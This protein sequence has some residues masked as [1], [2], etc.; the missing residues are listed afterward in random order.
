MLAQLA[1]RPLKGRGFRL[2]LAY[3]L[4]RTRALKTCKSCGFHNI[5]N[6]EACLRCGAV[7]DAEKA[8]EAN[9]FAESRVD[10]KPGA[11]RAA[12]DRVLASTGRA[13]I[14]MGRAVRG[15][16]PEKVDRAESVSDRKIFR[17]A[18]LGLIPG[19]GQLYNRQPKKA[20]YFALVWF[21]GAAAC[22][23]SFYEPYANY[24]LYAYLAW[25]LYAFH[26]GFIT[27]IE[28]NR[29]YWTYRRSATA[30]V[31]WVFLL[32]MAMI[33][34]NFVLSFTFLKFR[35]M[36]ETELAPTIAQRDRLGID[37][38][39]YRFRE[40]RVGEIVFYDPGT[41]TLDMVKNFYVSD[42]T[43]G[44]ERIVGGPGQVFERRN[45]EFFLDG[46]AVPEQRGPIYSDEL[47]ADFSLKAPYN[48]YI[49][50]RTY[51]GTQTIAVTFPK[52]NEARTVHNWTEASLIHRDDIFGRVWFTYYPPPHRR[53]FE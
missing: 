52:M 49:I 5:D 13:R 25:I 32:G 3:L 10:A 9:A 21:A 1:S 41:I 45:G 35:Y 47:R 44:F 19:C 53:F 7:L 15:L 42:P 29:R 43:N 34:A 4:R 28:I 37:I 24:V 26:D 39:S 50:L 33:V 31:G 20:F 22:A 12:K 30:Y 8:F 51:M 16:R 11:I 27:A 2:P 6:E 36:T 17:A 14:R 18:F 40:P 38:W 46:V 48:H 23:I